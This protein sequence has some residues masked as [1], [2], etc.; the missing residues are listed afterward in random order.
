MSC[1]SKWLVLLQSI[2]ASE[3][4]AQVRYYLKGKSVLLSLSFHPT[5]QLLV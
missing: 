2:R 3:I 1:D 5:I 4:D